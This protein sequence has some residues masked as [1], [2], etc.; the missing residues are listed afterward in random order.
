MGFL[1]NSVDAA[2]TETINFAVSNA[3][4]GFNAAGAGLGCYHCVSSVGAFFVSPTIS[5]KVLFVTGAVLNG[6][7]A[8]A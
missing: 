2:A 4:C 7:S 5:G 8:V 1:L 6:I 3:T